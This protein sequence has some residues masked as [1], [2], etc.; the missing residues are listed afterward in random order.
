MRQ[1]VQRFL[2]IGLFVALAASGFLL[3][4]CSTVQR[5]VIAPPHNFSGGLPL[6]LEFR[7]QSIEVGVSR[8]WLD[9]ISTRLQYGF[10][11][12]DEPS[13]GHF[14]DYTAHAIFATITARWP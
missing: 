8:R 4:S 13:R 2:A 11:K 12:Y 7:R 6:G 10:Y 3:A 9:T 14:T 1:R 5:S